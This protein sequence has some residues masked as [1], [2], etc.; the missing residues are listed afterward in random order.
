MNHKILK[1]VCILIFSISSCGP[2]TESPN[3][4]EVKED[5]PNPASKT[6]PDYCDI[7]TFLADPNVLKEAKDLWTNGSTNL[8]NIYTI[9]DGLLESNDEYKS[10]Y[11]LV[12]SKALNNHDGELTET[13]MSKAYELVNSNTKFFF[14]FFNDP[15]C[16][17]TDNPQSI[18]TWADL[19]GYYLSMSCDTS[20]EFDEDGYNKCVEEQVKRLNTKCSDCQMDNF[21]AKMKSA[22]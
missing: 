15:H 13:A 12:A 19:Y 18:Y 9:L 17:L 8:N 16:L 3:K 20:G 22:L 2:S 7:Q 4:T 14:G 1:I 11:L 5:A 6:T 10:F 21:M